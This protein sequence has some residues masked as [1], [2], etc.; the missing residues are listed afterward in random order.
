MALSKKVIRMTGEAIA[1]I[2]VASANGMYV[3]CT[4]TSGNFT[5]GTVYYCNGTTWISTG[6]GGG[7]IEFD[8]EVYPDGAIGDEDGEEITDETG[9]PIA[10]ENSVSLISG[11]NNEKIGAERAK[12]DAEG[13]DFRQTYA[14]KSDIIPPVRDGGTITPAATVAVSNNALSSVV[15]TELAAIT[16]NLTKAVGEVANFAIEFST[17]VACA[18]SVTV[19]GSAIKRSAATDGSTEANKFYQITCVGA[20]W[21]MAEFATP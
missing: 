2:S 14:K 16:F 10:D 21:T 12:C 11:Y 7:T 4:S 19:N 20:C 13:N 5:A 8:H 1:G 15:N 18:V 17:S 3:A 6:G 9:E